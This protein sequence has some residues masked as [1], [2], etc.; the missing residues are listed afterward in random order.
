MGPCSTAAAEIHVVAGVLSDAQG[1][2]LIAQRPPGRHMAGRWEFPG[3]KLEAGEEP[4][5]GLGRELGEELGIELRS[6]EPLLRLSHRYPD[7]Q[8][9][10]E[11]WRILRYDG[12]PRCCDGQA[13]AWVTPGELPAWDLLEADR[14]IVTALRTALSP[15]VDVVRRPEPP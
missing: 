6:A 5:A 11:V 7:R 10:L 1:R 14:P 15:A 3:G 12:E 13:L 9:H 4:L 8:V 2:V